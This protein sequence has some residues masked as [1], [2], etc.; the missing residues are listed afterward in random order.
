MDTTNFERTLIGFRTHFRVVLALSLRDIKT[1]VGGSYYG[2]MFGMSLPLGHIGIVLL[3]YTIMG[4]KAALGTDN[5]T[6]LS[7]AILPFIV[8]SYSHQKLMQAFYQNKPLLSFPIVNVMSIVIARSLVEILESTL[9]VVITLTTIRL[10]G[11]EIFVYDI[12]MATF[13]IIIAYALGI[14]T[15]YLFG[16]ISILFPIFTVIGYFIIPLNWMISGVF[17]MPDSLPDQ[18][19]W[20]VYWFP[21]A[22]IVDMARAATYSSYISTFYSLDYVFAI[23]FGNIFIAILVDKIAREKILSA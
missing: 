14:S 6:Y 13:S 9:I 8:W 18:I 4:R 10:L 5:V 7:T 16:I 20:V 21:I 3:I 11:F 2:F 23:V 19:R 15:G 17:F 22:H 12:R 1:R